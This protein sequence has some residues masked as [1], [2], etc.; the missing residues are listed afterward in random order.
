MS[1]PSSA[2]GQYSPSS[3]IGT[4]HAKV[5]PAFDKPGGLT[6]RTRAPDF[7]MAAVAN[8]TAIVP[9]TLTHSSVGAVPSPDNCFLRI[10][11]GQHRDLASLAFLLAIDD[12][13]AFSTADEATC[14]CLIWLEHELCGQNSKVESVFE[15]VG[16]LN[17]T[18]GSPQP[19]SDILCPDAYFVDTIV[20][21][22]DVSLSP[23]LR[24]TGNAGVG[25]T[26][27]WAQFDKK[28]AIS[29]IV[30]FQNRSASNMYATAL[31]REI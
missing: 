12:G 15:Y 9:G 7:G 16:T 10:H 31:S 14:D 20:A 18:G 21:G 13:S 5:L 28:G 3:P 26:I 6:A 24:V 17:L 2:Q 27:A 1:T 23:G 25:A 22:E 4:A 11:A 8:G 30:A 19:V 29:I